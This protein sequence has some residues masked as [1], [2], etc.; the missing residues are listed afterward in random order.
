MGIHPWE[1]QM[2]RYQREVKVP[3]PQQL[4]QYT[5]EQIDAGN[6]AYAR[7]AT[8]LRLIEADLA[9]VALHY[10]IDFRV[11]RKLD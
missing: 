9:K 4:D 6:L 11:I 10:T 3:D 7:I 1:M 5:T 2:R 8:V